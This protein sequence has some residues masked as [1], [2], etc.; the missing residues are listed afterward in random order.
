MK[1]TV[2]FYKTQNPPHGPRM[3]LFLRKDIEQIIC[4]AKKSA[5]PQNSKRH[6]SSLPMPIKEQ[7]YKRHNPYYYY[8][9]KYGSP[10]L[11]LSALNQRGKIPLMA[12]H[13]V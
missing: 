9:T 4:S 8:T 5:K 3:P 1:I 12:P 10:C 7:R 6:K 2:E 13:Y 11:F